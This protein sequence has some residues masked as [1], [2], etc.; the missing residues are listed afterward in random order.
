MTKF[1]KFGRVVLEICEQADR[2]TD[3]QTDTLIAILREIKTEVCLLLVLW[4]NEWGQ[5]FLYILLSY[6]LL[7][8][9]RFRNDLVCLHGV[10]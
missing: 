5:N 3:R 8:S 6:I 7:A 2:Q 10:Y 9:F 4:Q 1:V